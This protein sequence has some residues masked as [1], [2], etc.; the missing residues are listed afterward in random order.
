MSLPSNT[1]LVLAGCRAIP[2]LLVICPGGQTLFRPE[3]AGT[4]GLVY[5]HHFCDLSGDVPYPPPHL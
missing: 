3:A 4:L 2:R 5:T 1:F